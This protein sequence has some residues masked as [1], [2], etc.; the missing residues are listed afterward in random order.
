MGHFVKILIGQVH[1]PVSLK[2]KLGPSKKI[3]ETKISA[4]Q[5]I[6]LY[7]GKLDGTFCENSNRLVITGFSRNLMGRLVEILRDW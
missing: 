1:W 5:Y 2:I 3:N 4:N 6:D 7:S